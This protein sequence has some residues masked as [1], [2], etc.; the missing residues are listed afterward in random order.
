MSSS[1]DG[2]S[3]GQNSNMVSSPSLCRG[4][5][6]DAGMLVLVIVPNDEGCEPGSGMFNRYETPQIT[7]A[8]FQ[9]SEERFDEGLSSET[10]GG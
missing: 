4:D 2:A 7:D 6:R 10:R 8:V 9:C 3:F 5:V 1:K